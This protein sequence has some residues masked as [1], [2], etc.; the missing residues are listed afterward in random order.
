MSNRIGGIIEL[1]VNG[2]VFS[3]KGSFTYN[4]GRNRR[5]GVLG[6]DKVHGFKEMPQ[7]PFI[8]G[9]ITDSP[10][11]DLEQLVTLQDAT[12]MLRLANGKLIVLRQAWYAAEGTGNTEEG[13]IGVRFEGK[14]AEEVR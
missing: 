4:I 10:S 13:N 6:A 3:A 14:T 2:S 5:E 9:E 1:K 8:E 7:I 11:L 12:V